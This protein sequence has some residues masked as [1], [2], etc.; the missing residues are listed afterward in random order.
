MEPDVGMKGQWVQKEG[1]EDAI[2]DIDL[3][4]G[5]GGHRESHDTNGQGRD[6]ADAG[7]S[8]KVCLPKIYVMIGEE[9]TYWPE[10]R[11]VC[12]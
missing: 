2:P 12:S 8:I 1:D 3:G 4:G 11:A 10:H 6:G 9:C 5:R 7:C